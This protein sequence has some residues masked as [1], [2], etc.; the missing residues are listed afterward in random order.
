ME[1]I[2]V[3]DDVDAAYQATYRRRYPTIVPS[4]VADE[5]RAATLKVVSR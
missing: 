5:A 2:D 1:A 3:N 4:I